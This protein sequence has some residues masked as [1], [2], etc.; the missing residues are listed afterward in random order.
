MRDALALW[1][2]LAAP[3]AACDTALLLAVDVS[4]SIDGGEYALQA[5]GIAYAV[6]DAQVTEVL[7]RGQVALAVVQWSGAGEQVLSLPWR[8]MLSPGD[9]EGLAAAALAMPRAFVNSDTAVGQAVGFATDA[10]AAVPDCR[11]KVIDLSGDGQENAGFTLADTRDAA[12]RAGIEINAI[13]IEESG[14]PSPVTN[15][16]LRSLITRNGF[17]LTT[18]G[19]SGYAETLRIKLLRELERPVG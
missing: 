12:I 15:Y 9:V 5:A 1:L 4:G 2:A 18:R 17:V 16:F 6:S 3:A 19:L 11:R 14:L 10:F 7:V 13:A 8:R